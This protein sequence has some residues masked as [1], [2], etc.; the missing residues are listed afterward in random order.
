MRLPSES[1]LSLGL[2]VRRAMPEEE[3]PRSWTATVASR[4][5]V[6]RHKSPPCPEVFALEGPDLSDWYERTK[7]NHD[8]GVLPVDRLRVMLT[9]R[10]PSIASHNL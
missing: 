5:P 4:S 8:M 1:E 3:H 10:W 2:Y 9:G 7:S 6:S